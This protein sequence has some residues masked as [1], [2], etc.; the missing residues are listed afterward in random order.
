MISSF[1]M[2]FF[3]HV[4]IRLG[5]HLSDSHPPVGPLFTYISLYLGVGESQLRIM[6]LDFLHE[7]QKN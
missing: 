3:N 6:Y 4:L 2:F 1:R 7:L 5:A